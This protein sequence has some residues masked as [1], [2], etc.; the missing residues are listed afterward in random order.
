[1]PDGSSK[2]GPLLKA[3]LFLVQGSVDDLLSSLLML[4]E[5]LGSVGGDVS[6]DRSL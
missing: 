2:W 6:V 3:R 5:K 1:M 4:A